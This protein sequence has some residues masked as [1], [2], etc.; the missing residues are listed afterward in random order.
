MSDETIAQLIFEPG[1]SAARVA[2]D[3]SGRSVGMHAVRRH[4]ADLGGSI[5]IT[6]QCGQGSAFVITLALIDGLIAGIG[7]ERYI[8]PLVSIVASIQLQSDALRNVAGGGQL[9]RFPGDYLPLIQ[10][11]RVFGGDGA[12]QELEQGLVIVV[13]NDG[14]RVGLFVDALVGQQQAVVKLLEANYRRVDGVSGATILAD[15]AVAL[16]VN[17]PGLIRLQGRRRAA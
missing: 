3:L 14:A 2:T 7:D 4:V 5:R 6:R 13:E 10:L 16:I 1:F 9:F 15:G 12:R 8:V 11:H 17:M